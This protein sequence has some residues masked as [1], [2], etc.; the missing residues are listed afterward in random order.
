MS[1]EEENAIKYTSL[2]LYAGGADTVSLL[3]RLHVVS[4]PAQP[5]LMY[6]ADCVCNDLLHR[7]YDVP[8]RGAKES[9]SG[10]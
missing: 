9:S 10:G 3:A 5:V 4:Q 8:S 6:R 7:A 1:A 2:A